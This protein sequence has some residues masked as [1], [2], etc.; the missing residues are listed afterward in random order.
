MG[1]RQ[2]PLH[3]CAVSILEVADRAYKIGSR[4]VNDSASLPSSSII[5]GLLAILAFV[6]DWILSLESLAEAICPPLKQLFDGVDELV[7]KAEGL[8]SKFDD[9]IAEI[10]ALVHRVPY[11]GWVLVCLISCLECLLSVLT[12][13]G[14]RVKEKEIDV[15]D[16][17]I[18][19]KGQEI[20][21][22]RPEI[23]QQSDDRKPGTVQEKCEKQNGVVQ[24]TDQEFISNNAVKDGGT[25]DRAIK[26][27]GNPKIAAEDDRTSQQDD[28]DQKFIRND[29]ETNEIAI[30]DQSFS[31]N[32]SRNE[33]DSD[34]R[35]FKAS[36]EAT[37]VQENGQLT[38]NESEAVSDADPEIAN[39]QNET[40]E[41]TTE[42]EE[43]HEM[44][45][46]PENGD[47][48]PMRNESAADEETNEREEDHE[49]FMPNN[50]MVIAP[51]N[52]DH[53]PT[54]NESAA[55][56]ETNERE[57]D[58][59][60][61]M[62]N[63]EM[64][65]APENGDHKPT[66]NESAADE[67]TNEREE[68]HETF[69]PNNEMVI[70]PENGDHKATRNES[71]ADEETN[72]REEDHETFMPNN[73]MVIAPENGDHKPTRNE[74]A[75]D[76]HSDSDNQTLAADEPALEQEINHQ[77]F[78]TSNESTSAQETDQHKLTRMEP[79]LIAYEQS[80]TGEQTLKQEA[81]H[82]TSLTNS[83]ATATQENDN[84]KL[85]CK[86]PEAAAETDPAMENE[87]SKNEQRIEEET[88]HQT[89]TASNQPEAVVP[90]SD[91][92]TEEETSM[93]ITSK[94]LEEAVQETDPSVTSSAIVSET[95]ETAVESD[96]SSQMKSDR[97]IFPLLREPK[98][99]TGILGA[100]NLV[101]WSN[102]VGG[103]YKDVL[104]KSGK[105]ANSQKASS[106]W[107]RHAKKVTRGIADA[108]HE[109]LTREG[110]GRRKGRRKNGS[111][112][113][114]GFTD[115]T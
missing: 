34:Q 43:D 19:S 30:D 55:D 20:P 11:M 17:T 61:F 103:T 26:S 85:T 46:A 42:R 51:E 53:K 70:A 38:R 31:S 106:K 8:P 18:Y 99:Q 76:D 77:A 22:D 84:E 49:T 62:P 1:S 28:G 91:Q 75:A 33:Q 44:V 79:G 10:P 64:V 3:T 65:I 48:K 21:D 107:K 4:N 87:Q 78:L 58:H 90:E 63:N 14:M 50:E 45:I 27:N 41:E 80:E 105:E 2:Q 71:A 16:A 101:A 29:S 56:E 113:L 25:E 69:M 6:D 92:P 36:N 72:E 73:E 68:E 12:N 37:N 100:G 74:S 15:V 112:Q 40:D 97:E 98:T 9:A 94:N 89:F 88:N 24:E 96:C 110:K 102:V 109:A 57:E 47:H 5:C 60:T 115:A 111:S 52:G 81:D 13:L 82:Q 86:E 54:R 114:P 39:G 7:K 59:E 66:R 108:D 67:E 83:E 23:V 95:D 93:R 32:E 104:V 35:I